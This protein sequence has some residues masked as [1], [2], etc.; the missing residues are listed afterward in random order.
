MILYLQQE[1]LNLFIRV[2]KKH[3]FYIQKYE[4]FCLIFKLNMK[5]WKLKHSPC[6]LCK[7]YLA[8]VGFI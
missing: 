2:Q 3:P 1:M 6:R 8:N 7:I 5:L 4:I